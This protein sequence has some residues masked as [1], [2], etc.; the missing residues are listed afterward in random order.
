[1]PHGGRGE[2]T[3]RATG[4]CLFRVPCRAPHPSFLAY[5]PEPASPSAV[6]HP[7]CAAFG[8]CTRR[9]GS[10]QQ[11][12][13]LTPPLN[14]C[15]PFSTPPQYAFQQRKKII[16]VLME[17]DYKPTGWLGALMGTRLYFNMSDPRTIPGKVPGLVKELGDAGK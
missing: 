7:P 5:D 16:P 17:A 11:A 14:A 10:S 3:G 1:M 6:P 15:P 4:V 9:V 12:L 2:G 13:P 8:W